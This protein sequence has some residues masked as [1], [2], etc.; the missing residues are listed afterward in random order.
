MVWNILKESDVLKEA[1]DNN[2]FILNYQ[3]I[4]DADT[5]ETLWIEA[6]MRWRSSI[7]GT[8]SPEKFI[9]VL[10]EKNLMLAAGEWVLKDACVQMKKWHSCGY[11]SSGIS[12][13]V[14]PVQLRQHNFAEVVKDVLDETGLQPGKLSLEITESIKLDEAPYVIKTLKSLRK[15]GVRISIDDFG[16]GY[17]C[18]KYLQEMDFTSLKIDRAF[19][20]NLKNDR[21]RMLVESIISLGHR[22][23]VKVIAE[24]TETAEQCE[25]L[26]EMGCD[27]LQGYYFCKPI[28]AEKL[29]FFLENSCIDERNGSE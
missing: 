1:L 13:N 18:L 6:L 3:P 11:T 29:C 9:P 5:Y 24:G 14:S 15:T 27:M 10:E 21:G 17:N 12:V 2:E 4:V 25:Q 19:V 7:I 8:V 22:M 26:R 23:G 28:S 20:S 16:T